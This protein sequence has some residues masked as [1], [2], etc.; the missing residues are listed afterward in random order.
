MTMM[1]KAKDKYGIAG[2]S[3]AGKTTLTFGIVSRLKSYGVLAGGVFDQ[4]RKFSFD[5]KWLELDE[6]A[7]NWM[8]TNMIAKE[9]ELTLHGDLDILVSDRTVVDFFAYYLHQY[10]TSKLAAG[11]FEYVREWAKTYKKIYV[12]EP[13]P[14]H[15][16]GKRPSDDFRNG[17]HKTLMDKL[18]PVIPNCVLI[19]RGKVLNDIMLTSRLVKPTAKSEFTFENG[20]TAAKSL[21]LPLVVKMVERKDPLSD[22]DIYV[23]TEHPW[24]V[25]V[26]MYKRYLSSLFGDFTYLDVKA[27]NVT[28][29]FDNQF[30]LFT[31][32]GTTQQLGTNT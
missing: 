1:K 28:D 14:F 30:W 17:V 3:C 8:I 27:T 9:I 6:I 32:E 15:D 7:Q 22:V 18:V 21:G 29:S 5:K 2:T 12:L 11:C 25:D 26:G 19:E 23:V 24:T 10:P 16:D 4:D 13:L 20:T 31:P